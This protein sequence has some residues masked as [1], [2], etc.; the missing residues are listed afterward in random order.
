MAWF[1]SMTCCIYT[2][3]P[4]VPGIS[5]NIVIC[6][7]KFPPLQFLQVLIKVTAIVHVHISW[8]RESWVLPKSMIVV[9]VW[10]IEW[11]LTDTR[12]RK[13]MKFSTAW[14]CFLWFSHESTLAW[15]HLSRECVPVHLISSHEQSTE[16]FGIWSDGP[17][18]P[19][20][21]PLAWPRKQLAQ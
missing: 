5:Y 16:S 14:S 3:E 19:H 4:M 2:S 11:G 8:I 13:F 1:E 12:G 6:P 10:M 9:F 18:V 15:F 20:I 21:P 17:P 7:V